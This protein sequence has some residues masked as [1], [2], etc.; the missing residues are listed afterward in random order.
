M[1]RRPSNTWPTTVASVDYIVMRKS[2]LFPK[3]FFLVARVNR[4]KAVC[5][6]RCTRRFICE[7]DHIYR[8][9]DDA[10]FSETSR[11]P[12]FRRSATNG[13]SVECA[14]VSYRTA[15]ASPAVNGCPVNTDVH[16]L[17]QPGIQ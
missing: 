8:V 17:A 13:R 2:E 9:Q 5:L 3:R 1:H 4:A 6:G 14:S 11:S 10:A 7:R 12:H 15:T 16:Y